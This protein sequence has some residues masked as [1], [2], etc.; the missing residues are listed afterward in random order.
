MCTALLRGSSVD[1]IDLATGAQRSIHQLL[2]PGDPP[3][4]FA[5][6]AQ[7]RAAFVDGAELFVVDAGRAAVHA[8]SLP[9]ELANGDALNFWASPDLQQFY[10]ATFAADSG[11]GLLELAIEGGD[12]WRRQLPVPD[13]FAFDMVPH[14]RT[15]AWLETRAGVQ[16]LTTDSSGARQEVA[17]AR[18]YH[19]LK[20]D[21]TGERLLLSGVGPTDGVA[22][23]EIKEMQEIVLPVAGVSASWAGSGR[24]LYHSGT[25]ALRCLNVDSGESTLLLS[26]STNVDLFRWSI[27]ELAHANADG[28]V[29]A[30]KWTGETGEGKPS[31]GTVFLDLDEGVFMAVAAYWH[32]LALV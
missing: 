15:M 19:Q 12:L 13:S 20:A 9:P 7:G 21:P 16:Y 32:G 22:I 24:V 27:P 5:V 29:A 17:L 26:W 18:R 8:C 6:G 10:F 11:F 28:S 1:E 31:A 2:H 25:A 23:V 4:S 14:R 3:F 30:W